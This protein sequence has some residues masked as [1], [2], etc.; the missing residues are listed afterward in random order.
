MVLKKA[1]DK[2]KKTEGLA[3]FLRHHHHNSLGSGS[4]SGGGGGGGDR[5]EDDISDLSSSRGSSS[6]H[7]HHYL[8]RSNVSRHMSRNSMKM[9]NEEIKQELNKIVKYIFRMENDNESNVKIKNERE[10][11]YVDG[12]NLIDYSLLK[13]R[14]EEYLNR[15]S[16]VNQSRSEIIGMMEK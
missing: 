7:N 16:S 9:K 14:I 10:C 2:D 11:N 12:N 1:S 13:Q 5:R 15:I 3:L 4:G 6:S 8:G